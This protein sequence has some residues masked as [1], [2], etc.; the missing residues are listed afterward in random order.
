MANAITFRVVGLD[1][2]L[3]RLKGAPKKLVEEVS[4]ELEAGAD[5]IAAGAIKD[6]P[7]DEGGIRRGISVARKNRTEFIVT[8]SARYSPFMEWG[9]KKRVSIPSSLTSYAA[10]FKGIKGGTKEQFLKAITSW[11]RRKGIRFDSTVSFKSG[12]RK[13]QRKKMT[14]KDTAYIIYLSI[15]RN[16]VKPQPFFFKNLDKQAPMILKRVETVLNQTI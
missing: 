12:K 7:V 13:G 3:A 6:A 16:G 8:S 14:I 5:D 11:V 4:G 15:L 10:Q 9:T 1:Q 2:L